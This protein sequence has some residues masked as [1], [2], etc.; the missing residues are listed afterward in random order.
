MNNAALTRRAIDT[1]Q[2]R[3]EETLSSVLGRSANDFLG[4][5]LV[6]NTVSPTTSNLGV[7]R[8][9]LNQTAGH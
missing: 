8:R 9:R 7:T 3:L 4:N 5:G 1:V 6:N 2:N